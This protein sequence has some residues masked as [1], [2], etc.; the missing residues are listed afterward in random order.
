M[1][2]SYSPVRLTDVVN[3]LTGERADLTIEVPGPAGPAPAPAIDGSELW[4]LPGLY[5][6][7]AHLPILTRGLRETDRWRALAGGATTVNTAVPWHQLEALDLDV[8]TAYFASTAFPQILPIL[9]VA[10]DVDSEAFPKWLATFG[11]R[12]R[13]TWMPTI[14]LYSD[15]PNFWPNLE[16]IWA[17]GCKAA[18][19][20][21][22]DEAFEGVLASRGGP[23][24][25]RHV[26]SEAMSDRIATRPNS[27]TQTSPHFLIELP[28]GRPGE[29]HVLPPVPD[30]DAARASLLRILA[31]RVDL[32]AS[33]HNAPIAG[34][35]GPGLEIEQHL[36]PALLTLV[37]QGA[38]D[39]PTAI[40]KTT[41]A[42]RAV[43]GPA[44]PLADARIVV[45][46]RP[47]GPAGLW[48]GQEARRAAFRHVPL[49]G[50]I[51][52]VFDSGSGF[53]L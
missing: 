20:F 37:E 25:F 19:Y 26:V 46:P 45:D 4:V 48:P 1:P 44:Q 18:I 33:D 52:A 50:A 32:I 5:D 11:E 47:T 22:S 6:A 21:Y 49:S 14:K 13:Q 36:L 8:V 15:N 28:A 41:T 34:N 43:F 31:E 51:V 7:D 42:A 12:I 53:F 23:V 30:D 29:L 3:P 16:A 10:S 9:S 24:H 39:L 2:D 40:A 35:T 17:V 38:L 27:T